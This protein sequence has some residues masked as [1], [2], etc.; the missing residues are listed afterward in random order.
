MLQVPNSIVHVNWL[1]QN[2]DAPNLIILD[3]T[4]PKVTANLTGK[5][6]NK[7]QIK[8]TL[9]FDIKNDFSDKTSA[10]PNTV[11]SPKDFEEKAQNLG[12]QKDSCIVVYDDLGI[13]SSPRVWWLFNL[14]GF[15]NIA[16]LDG[17]FPA[18][19]NADFLIENSK[20]NQKSK[21]NFKVNYQPEKIVFSNEVL[22]ATKNTTYIILDARSSGRFYGTLP[23]PRKEVRS[24][25]IPTSK[26]LPYT[27]LL[28][29]I[30]F[31]KTEEIKAIF[32]KENNEEKAMIFSCGS[33]ITASILALAATM[34]NYKNIAVYD[35]SWTEWGSSTM[36]IEK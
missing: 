12:I 29:G 2:I 1:H 19:N 25:H 9:F 28:N 3:V 11:L 32:E 7:K 36:P 16:V 14:M 35:G 10:F 18:W 8:G 26:S 4:I 30:Y 13:Y 22:Q 27:A 24:G 17:G 5:A 31:K 34:V 20:K 23:E 33:G 21:G 15:S 6:V